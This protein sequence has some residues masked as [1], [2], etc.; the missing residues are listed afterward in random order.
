MTAVTT[1]AEDVEAGEK[2]MKIVAEDEL[3]EDQVHT[4]ELEESL[5]T[6]LQAPRKRL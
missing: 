5:V 6:Q 2:E 4:E 1:P 3:D